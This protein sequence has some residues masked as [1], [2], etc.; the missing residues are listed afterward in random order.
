MHRR[1]RDFALANDAG[2][3][4]T[5]WPLMNGGIDPMAAPGLLPA[6]ASLY[7]IQALHRYVAA[8]VA[9]IVWITALAAWRTQRHR[10]QLV[11]I[12]LWFAGL[13]TLQVGIGALLVGTAQQIITVTV[14]SE[15][16]VLFVGIMLVV[17]ISMAPQGIVGLVQKFRARRA[18]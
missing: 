2:S 5:D 10:P 15:L 18:R 4:F 11:R 17:F 9:I 14:S 3:V 6:A 13:F 7:E 1:G 12:S 16:N 8:V